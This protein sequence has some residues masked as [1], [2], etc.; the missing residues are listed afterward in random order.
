[1]LELVLIGITLK[2]STIDF[3]PSFHIQNL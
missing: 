3:V 1:V 2:H